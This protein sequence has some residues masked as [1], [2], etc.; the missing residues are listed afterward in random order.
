MSRRKMNMFPWSVGLSAVLIVL[1]LI[2]V[3]GVSYARYQIG[4]NKSISHTPRQPEQI[5]LG[6]M[7]T[8]ENGEVLFNPQAVGSWETV[9]GL[10]QLMFTVA[11]GNSLQD[12]ARQ[13]QRIQIR[14]AGSLGV[15]DGKETI[16]VILRVPQQAEPEGTQVQFDEILGNA[17]R[18]QPDSPMHSVFGE[19]WVFTFP[20]A[21]GK[22]RT[23]LLEGGSFSAVSMRILIDGM[24]LT[25][26]S[27]LQ[28]TVTGC[29]VP[30]KP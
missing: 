2:S 21:E 4:W 12:Y 24:E 7:V 30:E 20:D 18:I 9:D 11:N 19:G 6:Q 15:W 26:P 25:D 10:S 23:W 16:R 13:D 1:G 5:C 22:E 28:L 3:V 8:Q 17:T 29:F 27:L 14:L